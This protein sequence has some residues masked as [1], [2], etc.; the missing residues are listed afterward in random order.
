MA[1]NV[2][3]AIGPQSNSGNNVVS[4]V[5][6]DTRGPISYITIENRGKKAGE[7]IVYTEDVNEL[8]RRLF[9]D[10]GF[11]NRAG[12]KDFHPEHVKRFR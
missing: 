9:G 10:D 2:F 8:T 1:V 3:R 4:E 6:V 7:L 5:R 12:R 11:V